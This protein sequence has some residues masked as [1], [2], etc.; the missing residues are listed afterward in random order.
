MLDVS[1]LC[2]QA[3]QREYRNAVVNHIRVRFKEAFPDTWEGQLK[4]P[5]KKEWDALVENAQIRRQT[6]E[7]STP[8]TDSFDLLGVN[9]FSNLFEKYL[10]VLFPQLEER[11]DV[12]Q[13]EARQALLTWARAIKNFRDSAL[14]HPPELDMDRHDA[15]SLLDSAS[16]L[17]DFVNKEAA[18]EVRRIRDIIDS[19]LESPPLSDPYQQPLVEGSTLPPRKAVAPSFVGRQTELAALHSWLD[20]PYQHVYFLA[21]DG[22]KG[23][24]AIAYEFATFV[25]QNPPPGLEAVIWLSAKV[26]RFESGNTVTMES[27]DFGDL[28]SAL[29][30]VLSAYGAAGYHQDDINSMSEV[31]VDYMNQLPALIVMDDVD[32]LE[33]QNMEAMNFFLLRVAGTKSKV[34]FTTRRIPFNFVGTKATQVQGFR[35][36]SEEGLKFIDSRIALYGLDASGFVRSDKNTILE[37]CDGS[38]LYVQDL[39]RLCVVGETP[40][41]AV[42]LWREYRGEGARR[43]ALGREFDKLSEDAKLVLLTCAL[44]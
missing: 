20:E 39:L 16:R 33:G 9:H 21:G 43:Y 15:L 25:R 3:I 38:P 42:R 37:A 41:S 1:T 13:K 10:G 26:R 31:V 30:V 40:S 22:G 28:P 14:G 11:G 23:K 2:F 6:G 24:T 44:I 8:L 29:Q 32:S 12:V 19:G 5:F 34:L 27:P 36:G 18:I 17:L 4:S 35:P 7:I